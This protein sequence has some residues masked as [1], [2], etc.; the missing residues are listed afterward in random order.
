MLAALL[1]TIPLLMCMGYFFMGSLPLLVL[2]YD[3]PMDARFVRGFFNTYYVAVLFAAPIAALAHALNGQSGF[4]A[5]VVAIGV[6]ALVLRKF[7]LPHMDGLRHRI[8]SEDAT[9]ITEFRRIHVGGMV[10]NFVQLVLLIGGLF[11]IAK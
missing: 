2:K 6:L 1:A 4:A 5:G 11:H 3:T 10:L 7:L 9:A 8:E